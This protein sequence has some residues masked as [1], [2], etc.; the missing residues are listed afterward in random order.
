M[1]SV[2]A[3]VLAISVATATQSTA[4]VDKPSS[5]AGERLPA[6]SKITAT[7]V[8]E[9]RF[10]RVE[11]SAVDGATR[12]TLTRSVPPVP[13]AQVTL[14]NSPDTVYI[15]RDI[16]PGSSYYYLISAVNEAGI[17]GLKV[18]AP[19]VAV[20]EP[21]RVPMAPLSVRAEFREG[22][23][24]LSWAATGT[25]QR[26]RIQRVTQTGTSTGGG[27]LPDAQCCSIRD[28]LGGVAAGTRIHYFVTA[29]SPTQ[30]SSQAAR[31]NELTVAPDAA[32][33]TA[34]GQGLPGDSTQGE[35]PADSATPGGTRVLPAVVPPPAT[36][37][38]GRSLNLARI[39][40]FANLQLQK[41]R[42]ASLNESK[43]T[44]DS[45]GKVLGVAPGY[46]NIVVIGQTPDGS[47]ASLVQRV[48]V[49]R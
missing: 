14:P 4:Q 47:V 17:A 33:D 5:S 44:V 35:T 43:A 40:A 26:F 46:A 38:V 11:W 31:S 10:I 15:D 32:V 45:R 27:L 30:M 18:S 22:A 8:Q 29:I 49:K 1:R 34:G 9:G 24:L 37:K 7:L 41:P 16:R 6:P 36:L 23:I 12:Y 19:P 21:D 42:W 28:Q 20:T 25:G 3:A 48:D 39:P 2:T 13:A